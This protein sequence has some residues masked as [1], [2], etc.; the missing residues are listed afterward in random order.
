MVTS[1]LLA[2]SIVFP[3]LGTIAVALRF[4]VHRKFKKQKP[5]SDD[6]VCALAQLAAWGISIDTFVAAGMAGTDYT[7]PS[8]NPLSASIIFLRTLWIEGF[9]LVISL[10]LVKISVL[11]FY[12]RVFTTFKFKLAVH[13]Y[14]GILTAWCISMIICQLLAANPIQ[15]AWNPLA[16]TPLR[17]NYNAW[18][19]AFAGMSIV[20]DVV[21]LCFPFP[22]IFKLQMTW[23]RKLQVVAIFWLGIFCCVSSAVRFYF[24]YSEIYAATSSNTGPGRYLK[25]STAFI[26]GTVEPNT[27]IIAACLP[28]Y[29]PF[30]AKGQGLPSLLARFGSLFSTGRGNKEKAKQS[31]DDT[32]PLES[33]GSYQ[34]KGTKN[35]PWERVDVIHSSHNVDIER[36]NSWQVDQEPLKYVHPLQIQVTRDFTRTETRGN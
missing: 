11:L 21:V 24:L 22:V 33:D 12:A 27:S 2:V 13:I 6:W 15:N 8:L 34:L 36:A 25:T 28:C 18:S 16:T 10:S 20:F 14:V 1:A 3:I 32:F 5:S 29:A 7:Y 19:L 35:R 23:T 26:W 9:P 31:G 17:F 30:F 4:L